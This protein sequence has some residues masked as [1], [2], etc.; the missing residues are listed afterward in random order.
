MELKKGSYYL[1]FSRP[2]TYDID[3]TIEAIN[4]EVLAGAAIDCDPED[5]GDTTNEFYQKCLSNPKILVTPHIAFSTKQ[6]VAKG[7]EIAIQN[8]EAFIKG[9]PQNILNKI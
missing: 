2:Y 1:T 3:G 7:R 8:I 4:K 5:F 6:A 9:K